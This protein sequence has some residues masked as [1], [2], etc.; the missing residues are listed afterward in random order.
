MKSFGANIIKHA[1]DS[2]PPF[3][4]Y[5]DAIFKLV[6]KISNV[7]TVKN[8]DKFQK[9]CSPGAVLGP[10]FLRALL[11]AKL[12]NNGDEKGF[13]RVREAFLACNVC[14]PVVDG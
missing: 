14:A 2:N 11:D 5:A 6:E 13:F 3:K 12:S 10:K 4:P 1:T 8:L 9:A 7:D